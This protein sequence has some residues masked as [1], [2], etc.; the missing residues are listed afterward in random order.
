MNSL[1]L[2]QEIRGCLLMRSLPFFCTSSRLSGS[3]RHSWAGA[4]VLQF[5]NQIAITD[6]HGILKLCVLLESVGAVKDRT[7][8]GTP[9]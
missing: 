4:T 7:G 3:T 1:I 2:D 6:I 8:M 5:S 9:R